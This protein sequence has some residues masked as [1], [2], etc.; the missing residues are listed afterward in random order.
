MGIEIKKA[1][2]ADAESILLLQKLA[3]RSEAE[4]YNNFHIEPLTQTLE[5][6][7]NQFE[8]HIVLKAVAGDM[9]VGSVRASVDGETCYI[10]KLMVHPDYQNQGLGRMLMSAIEHAC[11]RLR[12]ELFTGGRSEKNLALYRKLGYTA[13]KENVVAADFAFIYLQKKSSRQ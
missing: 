5:Q 13:F 2:V 4:L 8:S 12:Y 7:Q 1:S 10:A 6:L 9:I 3:Y 11:P